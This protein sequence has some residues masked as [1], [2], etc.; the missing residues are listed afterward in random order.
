MQL[1]TAVKPRGLFKQARRTCHPFC[2]VGGPGPNESASSPALPFRAVCKTSPCQF[3]LYADDLTLHPSDLPLLM[4]SGQ[5][6]SGSS[7]ASTVSFQGWEPV[8]IQSLDKRDGLFSWSHQAD[9]SDQ[10]L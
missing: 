10:Q 7:Q 2:D 3:S 1:Y 5:S 8:W 4:A 6:F 9:D